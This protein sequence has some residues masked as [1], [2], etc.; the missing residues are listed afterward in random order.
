M[1][2][3]MFDTVEGVEAVLGSLEDFDAMLARRRAHADARRNTATGSGL[4]E[5]LVF[6]T[7][8]LDRDGQVHPARLDPVLPKLKRVI[9]REALFA[10]FNGTVTTEYRRVPNA[11]SLCPLC[12]AGWTV[13]SLSDSVWDYSRETLVHSGCKAKENRARSVERFHAALT[14]AGMAPGARWDPPQFA[15]G[16]SGLERITTEEVPNGYWPPGSN[17]EAS[18]WMRV[19]LGKED[20]FRVGDRKRVTEVDWSTVSRLADRDLFPD[21]EGTHEPGYVHCWNDEALVLALRVLGAHLR[22]IGSAG[23][24]P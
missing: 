10:V 3:G 8:W 18:P 11:L 9:P 12:N 22:K 14:A 7:L 2:A 20:V 16:A 4:T 17:P 6:G 19:H 24:V 1:I 13:E 23:G 15:G 5:F 21:W